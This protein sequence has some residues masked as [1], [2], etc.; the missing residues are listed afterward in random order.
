MVGECVWFL[1]TCCEELQTHL[2]VCDSLQQ[3]NENR[4]SETTMKFF[5]N[6]VS[7]EISLKQYDKLKAIRWRNEFYSLKCLVYKLNIFLKFLDDEMI[8][9]YLKA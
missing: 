4:T 1:F 8:F 7:T 5:V 6:F 2:F 9:T 3:V